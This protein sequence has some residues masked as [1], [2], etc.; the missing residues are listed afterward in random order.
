MQLDDYLASLNDQDPNPYLAGLRELCAARTALDGLEPRLV[1]E[2][3]LL[4]AS[5]LDV[6]AALGVRA[7][8]A[9]R[10][11]CPRGDGLRR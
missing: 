1:V 10:R 7:Q 8:T 9:H 11:H 4:G 6:G 2:A 3:R 5:W